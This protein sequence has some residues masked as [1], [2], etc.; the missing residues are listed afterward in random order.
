[1]EY[2]IAFYEDDA[3][4][5]ARARND[6]AFWQ[7]WQAYF[8]DLGEAGVM[9]AGAPLHDAERAVTVRTATD[10]RVVHDG[11]YADT[12]E[13]LGGFC[14]IDVPSLDAAL[15]WAE[16][17]PASREGAVEIRPILAL[18]ETEVPRAERRG[19][20]MLALYESASDFEQRSGEGAERYFRQWQ[21]YGEAVQA[22]GVLAAGSALREPATAT[23]VRV[24]E[25]GMVVHDGP[26][27]DTKEQLGGYL[28]LD[29]PS[30]D[31]A[32]AWASRSPAASG[33]AVE[34]RPVLIIEAAA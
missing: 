9:R 7:P 33:G 3:A 19:T 10:K 5:A 24:G 28:L 26:Y 18:T 32:I 11:P 14:V 6:E 25:H 16:R 34:V 13:Q 15:H 29:V 4:F 12:K 31:D 20:F 17:C 22:A 2:L 27:A 1:M 8:R 23:V 21:A 30:I